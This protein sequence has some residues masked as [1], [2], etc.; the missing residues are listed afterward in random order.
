VVQ[1]S[2]A[3]ALALALDARARALGLELFAEPYVEGREFNLSLLA[4]R[5]GVEA[6]PAAEIRFQD[7]PPG[8]PRLVGYAAKWQPESFEYRST[9][10]TFDLPRE[11]APLVRELGRLA[12]LAWSALGLAGW[13][14]VDF[15]VDAQRCPWILEVNANPCLSPDAGFCAALDRAGV[16]FAAAIERIAAAALAERG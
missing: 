15:R 6:L 9:P 1:A 13:A 5:G 4:K 7:F 14:R 11:D 8:K 16:T 3:R 2:S 10:R 12:Q